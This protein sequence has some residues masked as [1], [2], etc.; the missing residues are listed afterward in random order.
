MRAIM[1]IKQFLFNVS[2]LSISHMLQV[3]P[4]MGFD[5]EWVT[6][7]K[8]SPRPIS[9]LQ[10]A[11]ANSDICYLIRLNYLGKVPEDLRKILSD[12][13][14]LKFGVGIQVHD[15]TGICLG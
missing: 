5:C 6:P 7:R 1:A 8:M 10:L 3:H 14:V 2:V 15:L 4:I 13:K 12:A 11:V 9:L